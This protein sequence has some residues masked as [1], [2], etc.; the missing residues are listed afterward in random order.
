MFCFF[1]SLFLC[2]RSWAC[3]QNIGTYRN[4]LVSFIWVETVKKFYHLKKQY[5]VC[6]VLII[7]ASFLHSIVD[8]VVWSL[9]LQI[10][11]VRI[12]QKWALCIIKTCWSPSQ[13]LPFQVIFLYKRLQFFLKPLLVPFSSLSTMQFL[14][15][16]EVV[17]LQ[18]QNWISSHKVELVQGFQRLVSD[19][20][21]SHAFSC[22][23]IKPCH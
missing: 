9:F 13:F 8:G 4:A 5:N 15:K 23:R 12:D 19:F 1:C 7:F 14:L 2:Y 22:C 6:N 20:L 11:S 21:A 3:H 17:F 18:K 16:L 10:R